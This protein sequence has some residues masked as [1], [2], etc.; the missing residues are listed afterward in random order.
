VGRTFRFREQMSLT[1]RAEFINIFNRTVFPNP[2]A[3]TP[4]T[5]ATCFVSGNSGPTGACQ[6][7]ATIASGFG[8]MQTANIPGTPRQGQIAARFRF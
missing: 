4:L 7:G 8:F 6:P 2:S 1:I 5:P 3:T